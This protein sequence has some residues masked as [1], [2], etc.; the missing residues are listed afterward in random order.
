MS[1]KFKSVLLA[2]AV[3]LAL[4]IAVFAL[5]KDSKAWN[6]EDYKSQEL[7][8]QDCYDGYQC[9]SFK[10]PVD[11]EKVD[12]RSFTLKVLRHNASDQKNKLGSI[13]VNPGGPGGS[14]TVYAYN[15]NFIFSSE[16]NRRYDIVGFDPRG[17][18]ES[19]EIRCLTNTEED[20]FL[21]ADASDGKAA[22]IKALVAISKN[23]ADKCAKAAGSKLGH[24]STL[25]AAKDMEILRILLNEKKLNYL[26]KSYGTYLGTLYAALF[27]ESVGRIVLDGAVSPNVTTK[28]QQLAQAIAFD[29]ALNNFLASHESLK[30]SD[31]KKLLSQ[32]AVNPMKGQDGRLANQATV[33]TAIAKTL[34]DSG[35]GWND[36]DR[37]LEQA[38]TERN[39][40]AIFE[41]A[42]AYNNRDTN[43]NYY[44]N[45]T[46]VSIMISCLDWKEPRTVEEMRI[47]RNEYVK[48]APVF[49]PFLNFAGLPCKYWQAKP[50]LPKMPLKNIVTSPILVIGVTNDPATPYKWAQ[51]LTKVF[52]NAKLLTLDGDGHTGHSQGN[53]CIDSKVDS[54]FLTGKIAEEPLICG[55]SGT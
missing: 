53:K 15:A 3:I 43:G 2:L 20:A 48:S 8:W 45:Q 1:A 9:S 5:N 52:T 54:Y 55:K 23:F 26:G 41:Q 38:I 42:D 13:L 7:S 47:D 19:E 50:Q 36:L 25:E 37:M 44:S 14:A 24:Y 30:L 51:D 10:V 17:I 46:D 33:I 22:S 34:Y 4:G 32:A 28:E 18:N 12:S 21:S 35:D 31:I 40:E 6:L 27:P 49:G 16:I 29:K 39:P 11:Y